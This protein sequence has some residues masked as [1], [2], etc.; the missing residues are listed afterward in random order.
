ML[1]SLVDM[2]YNL[3]VR[4]KIDYFCFIFGSFLVWN[5]KTKIEKCL[6]GF[7][8]SKDLPYMIID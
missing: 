6:N 3:K 7:M 5:I 2:E 1:F 4:F 8:I